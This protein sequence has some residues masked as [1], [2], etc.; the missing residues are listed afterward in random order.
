MTDFEKQV[1]ELERIALELREQKES[2]S[3]PSGVGDRVSGIRVVGPD[4]AI[5]QEWHDE[6]SS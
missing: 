5:K 3:S 1:L 2:W 4:G 6:R